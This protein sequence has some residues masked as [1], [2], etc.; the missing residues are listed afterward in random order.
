MPLNQISILHIKYIISSPNGY[1]NKDSLII[2][3]AGIDAES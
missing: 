1:K 3:T 2:H